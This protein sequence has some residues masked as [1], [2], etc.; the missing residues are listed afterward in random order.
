MKTKSALAMLSK[1]EKVYGDHSLGRI[2]SEKSTEYLEQY[3]AADK[4]ILAR[5][6]AE[7]MAMPFLQTL[8]AKVA[9]LVVA[10]DE[11]L[12]VVT[13]FDLY[14]GIRKISD[15]V[16]RDV[17]LRQLTA[18]LERTWHQDPMG[19]LTYGQVKALVRSFKDSFPRSQASDAIEAEC[20]RVG[21]H[22]LP[23]AKLAR[24][25]AKI[26]TQADFET[27]VRDNKLDG[28]KIE[29]VRA[30][31]LIR[32]LVSMR[33]KQAVHETVADSLSKLGQTGDLEFT[34]KLLEDAGSMASTMLHDLDQ[35]ATDA[36][37]S[38]LEQAGQS[39]QDL[40][41]QLNEW[42]GGLTDVNDSLQLGPDPTMPASPKEPQEMEDLQHG[43][44]EE[45]PEMLAEPPLLGGNPKRQPPPAPAPSVDGE[46]DD[47]SAAGIGKKKLLDP[48]TWFATK[49]AQTI[50]VA[51]AA[52]KA[53]DL[54][55]GGLGDDLIK[56]A[57]VLDA[58]TGQLAPMPGKPHLNMGPEDD[59]E[60]PLEENMPGELG[61]DPMM[62]AGD[63]M[64]QAP[65][66]E[67]GVNVLEEIDQAADEIIEQAPPQ[68]MDYIQHEMGEGHL[69]PPGTAEW[70]AEEILNEGHEF[71]PPTEGWLQEEE[72]ELGLGG[73]GMPMPDE[74]GMPLT[75]KPGPPM[76]MGE[77]GPGG[78]MGAVIKTSMS[79]RHPLSSVE[80]AILAGGA[81]RNFIGKLG[82]PKD[83]DYF[84]TSIE[85][86]QAA[87]QKL[88]SLGAKL[89]ATRGHGAVYELDGRYV[90]VS[91]VI[92]TPQRII[93]GFDITAN[94]CYM[95]D[96]VVFATKQAMADIKS[97][98]IKLA[99]VPFPT[100]TLRRVLSLGS[101]HGFKCNMVQL[102][103]LRDG[104]SKEKTAQAHLPLDP[105]ISLFP[106]MVPSGSVCEFTGLQNCDDPSCPLADGNEGKVMPSGAPC[107]FTGLQNCNHPSCPIVQANGKIGSKETDGVQPAKAKGKGIPLPKGKIKQQQEVTTYAKKVTPSGGGKALTAEELE[108]KLLDGKTL[109]IGE[110]LIRINTNDEVEL[111]E[112][113]A[114][115]ACSLMDLDVAIADFMAMTGMKTAQAAPAPAAPA[116]GA[117][118]PNGPTLSPSDIQAALQ[119]YKSMGMGPV[120]AISM[121]KKDYKDRAELETPEMQTQILGISSSLWTSGAPAAASGAAPAAESAG[122]ELPAPVAS[123]V[124]EGEGKMK[125]PSVRKPKDHVQ[126]DNDV[127][128]DSE[129]KDL[130]PV[131]SGKIKTQPNKEQHGK[132]SPTDLGKDSQGKDLLPDAGKPSVTHS[133]TDQAGIKLPPKGLDGDHGGDDP[134]KTP[135]ITKNH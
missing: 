98:T 60:M 83:Y 121:L 18:Q 55:E 135:A 113:G 78:P 79:F 122:L 25:A 102:S 114:G 130:L 75:K 23:V 20:A 45:A 76:S 119:H 112:K 12:T 109:K 26:N 90:D 86:R 111:W 46:E 107:E 96:D 54:F 115:R 67:M 15:R 42:M 65:E 17:G 61:M 95:I 8:R 14:T 38:G 28:D 31:T 56:F 71:A 127:G 110:V 69:A 131:P 123:K 5:Q 39:L 104:A 116:G 43:P 88:K 105:A 84:F 100:S 29:Q 77:Q 133:P 27:L 11:S 73:G 62:D 103:A 89:Y 30:R 24:I 117:P 34:M 48:R 37:N 51:R 74:L 81:V 9:T 53:A 3:A 92:N 59:M 124:A 2:L 93:A 41:T 58:I 72:A 132:M 21:L 120:D 50:K 97:R 70:G 36:F 7:E 1:G 68:A 91:P 85:A 106:S 13:R 4:Q 108:A 57:T 125:T 40:S 6:Q 126:V 22:K 99:N 32:S 33:S 35:A 64:V 47:A 82:K 80:G 63:G 101:R 118:Q 10:P 87:I 128:E 94:Q 19:G 49:G 52:T 44:E 134:F 129:T 16:K 66:L